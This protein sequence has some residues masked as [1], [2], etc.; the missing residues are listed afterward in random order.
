MSC[1][2]YGR[3]WLTAALDPFHDNALELAGLPDANGS[4][5]FVTCVKQSVVISAPGVTT[6]WGFHVFFT[7]A[8]STGFG[9][10][11]GA[12]TVLTAGTGGVDPVIYTFSGGVGVNGSTLP[13]GPIAIV[14]T[15]SPSFTSGVPLVPFVSGFPQI[16]ESVFVFG[17]QTGTPCRLIAAG[18]EVTDVTPALYQQGTLTAYRAPFVRSNGVS[19]YNFPGSN[20]VN[21]GWTPMRVGTN[22][23]NT[24]QAMTIPDSIQY[25]AKEGALMVG[26]FGD[27]ESI[28]PQSCTPGDQT[29]VQT[30]LQGS[31]SPYN[32]FTSTEFFSW[33]VGNANG[34]CP[35]GV[36]LEGLNGSFGSFRVTAR[37]YYEYFPYAA[38]DP[39]LSLST[40]SAPFDA[41]ALQ[42]YSDAVKMLPVCVKVSEND[43]G[44]WFRRVSKVVLGVASNLP[45]V[46]GNVARAINTY[47]TP[48]T[49]KM[50]PYVENMKAY[51]TALPLQTKPAKS[52]ATNNIVRQPTP[53]VR[54]SRSNTPRRRG[55]TKQLTESVTRRPGRKTRVRFTY[56]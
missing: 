52:T 7:E 30:A 29:Y 51:S 15:S 25:A 18:F 33:N 46:T 8:T 38:T 14:S 44:D 4:N 17:E 19:R 2:R 53:F 9:A 22:P 48:N 5:S 12:Q 10:S 42:M 24:A 23:T 20:A 36:F 35:S 16:T 1:T 32:P 28:D 49:S 3:D 43:F 39:L 31:S 41:C 13:W 26:K 6:D 11:G 34:L 55:N 56:N 54:R 21:Q 27:L 50:L 40:P 45:G 47:M 37:L